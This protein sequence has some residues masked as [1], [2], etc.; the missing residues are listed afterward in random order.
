[1]RSYLILMILWLPVMLTACAAAKTPLVSHG[2]R[3]AEAGQQILVTFADTQRHSLQPITAPTGGYR[4]RAG[5]GASPPVSRAAAKLAKTYGLRPVD[6]WPIKALE[7]HCVVYQIPENRSAEEFV[8]L[9]ERDAAI[10]SVQPMNIFTVLA[11]N[12]YNDPYLELQYGL[13]SMQV[14]AAHRWASGRGIRIAVIDTGIDLDHPEIADRV[15][16]NRNF[17]DADG[18]GFTKDIHG[19]G[20]AGIIA[21]KANNGI[22]IVGVAPDAELLALKACWPET[23]GKSA[24]F[25]NSFTLA[26]AIAFAIE[27]RPDILNLS[28]AGPKDPLLSRLIKTAIGQGIIVVTASSSD[29]S[30]S[31]DFPASMDEAIT[32]RVAGTPLNTETSHNVLS[33]AAPG[34]D[35]LTTAPD[36]NY[37]FLSGSSLAAAHVSGVVALLLELQPDLSAAQ[38]VALLRENSQL[39]DKPQA[40]QLVNACATLVSVLGDGTEC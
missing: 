19:T 1:M 35:I 8:E 11:H 23:V 30:G 36:A 28:L 12:E 13:Q 9:L 38:V 15:K 2:G 18:Q 20:V 5:Y 39:D 24:A 34:R 3:A 29:G 25:C 40:H 31:T 6:E 26:K 37:G 10:E 27:R 4:R 33:L 7:I 14:Q 32:V 22:G 17:V 16:L 21:S